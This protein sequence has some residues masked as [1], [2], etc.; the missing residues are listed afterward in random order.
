MPDLLNGTTPARGVQNHSGGSYDRSAQQD[1]ADGDA[2]QGG[3]TLLTGAAD[4]I[5]PHVSG[6]YMVKTAGVDAMTLAAPTPGAD[7]NLSI[8]IYS[9]TLF[10]HTVTATTLFANGTALKSVATFGAFKGAGI[11]L[12]A[13][14]GVWQVVSQTTAPLT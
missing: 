10:A 1:I 5:N 13:F 4:A 2:F 8:G 14:N 12:R 3:I 6:N 9:D 11:L 7:D